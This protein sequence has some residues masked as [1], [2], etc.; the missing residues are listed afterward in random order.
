MAETPSL[1]QM[2]V[3]SASTE[4]FDTSTFTLPNH[5]VAAKQ[6]RKKEREAELAMRETMAKEDT[7]ASSLVTRKTSSPE[8]VNE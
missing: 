4:C 6:K 8:G 1:Q 3:G 7:A 2:P 5:R